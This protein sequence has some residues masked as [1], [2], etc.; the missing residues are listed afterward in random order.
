MGDHPAGY[1]RLKHRSFAA[2]Y[3]SLLRGDSPQGELEALALKLCGG[4]WEMGKTTRPGAWRKQLKE[5]YEE[6]LAE[7]RRTENLKAMQLNGAAT[8]QLTR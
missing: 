4:R 6:L 7:R 5:T 3:G 1:R 2:F 8:R